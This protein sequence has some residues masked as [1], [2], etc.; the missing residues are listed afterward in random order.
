[1]NFGPVDMYESSDQFSLKLITLSFTCLIPLKVKHNSFGPII[2]MV[3]IATPAINCATITHVTGQLLRVQV[4]YG[5][6][7]SDIST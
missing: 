2:R 4:G 7:F 6:F 1:M 5:K 3:E